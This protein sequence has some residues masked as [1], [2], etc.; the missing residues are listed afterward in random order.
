M[1]TFWDKLKAVPGIIMDALLRTQ[2]ED[3]PDENDS[4]CPYAELAQKYKDV[5]Y[6]PTFRPTFRHVVIPK[7]YINTMPIWWQNDFRRHIKELKEHHGYDALEH[8]FQILKRDRRGR[9]EEFPALKDRREAARQADE[10]F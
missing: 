5:E 6:S 2:R 9:F 3:M 1:S 10:L 8:D 4:G 7:D